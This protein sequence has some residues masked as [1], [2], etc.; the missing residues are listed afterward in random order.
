MIVGALNA[1]PAFA[2]FALLDGR[3]AFAEKAHLIH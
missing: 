2:G 3:F 1:N